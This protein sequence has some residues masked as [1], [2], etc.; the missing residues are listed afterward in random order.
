M[1]GATLSA[2]QEFCIHSIMVMSGIRQTGRTVDNRKGRVQHGLL[3]LWNGAV[4]FCP[5]GQKEVHAG[6]GDLICIPEGTRYTMQ[7]T[8]ADCT[9][10][11]VNF[12]LNT[13]E[14]QPLSLTDDIR[15]LA[16]DGNDRRIAGIMAEFERSSAAENLPAILRRKELLCR[17][18]FKVYEEANWSA[19]RNTKYAHLM[20]GVLLLQQTYLENLP[21]SR[22]AEACSI[23]V[24][25]F[26]SLFTAQYGVSPVQYRNRLRISR[27]R[28]ILLDGSCTV[29]EAAYACGFDNLAYFCRYY[30]RITGET[31]RETQLQGK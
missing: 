2:E 20:P 14:G 24:S 23:S 18:L 27:A 25:S 22:F 10:V 1:M 30:K 15:I 4:R 21:V 11:L 6:G 29:S 3:Y 8:A 28:S 31:P 7:Y 9:F 19:D 26:R 5:E 16:H 13:P 12:S 17:L